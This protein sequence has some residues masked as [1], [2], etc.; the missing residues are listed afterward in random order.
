MKKTIHI[1]K[2]SIVAPSNNISAKVPHVLSHGV[3]RLEN[4]MKVKYNENAIFI[5]Q[6]CKSM[7]QLSPK[8]RAEELMIAIKGTKI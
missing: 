6:S 5:H 7:E 2:V 4:F 1:M 3:E 8:S